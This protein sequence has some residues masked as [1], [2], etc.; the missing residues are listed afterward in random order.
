[1]QIYY[2]PKLQTRVE[3]EI[4]RF[5]TFETFDLQKYKIRLCVV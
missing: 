4:S 5:N 1:M 2:V 3:R